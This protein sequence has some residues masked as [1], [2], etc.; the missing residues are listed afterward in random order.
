MKHSTLAGTR[1]IPAVVAATLLSSCDTPLPSAAATDAVP[2]AAPAAAVHSSMLVEGVEL[3]PGI[4]VDVNVREYVNEDRPCHGGILSGLAVHGVTANARNWEPFADALFQGHGRRLCRLFAVDLPGHGESGLPQGGLLF[5]D[6]LLDDYVTTV[7]AVL[8]HLRS[9]NVRPGLLL[10]HSQ[11]SLVLMMTQ[12]RLLDQGSS[13]FHRYGARHIAMLGPV[14]PAEVPWSMAELAAAT[15]PQFVTSSTEL[16]VHAAATAEEWLFLWFSNASGALAT[17]A[18]SPT[19]V[20]DN[21]WNDPEPLLAL[22]QLVGAA[23]LHKPSIPAGAFAPDMGT[24]L[25]V[26]TFADDMWSPAPD[27][28]AI[29]QH[30]TGDVTHAGFVSVASDVPGNAVHGMYA[31]EPERVVAAICVIACR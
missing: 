18:P 24:T 4:I 25:Q 5:G 7:L 21:G 6:L 31:S 14:P 26:V 10:G 9:R 17:T 23:P 1:L 3:R 30:L 11:G 20:I 2:P 13:L 19:A 28:I 16:G 12:Q 29:Y 15:V 27:G 8:D 22:M